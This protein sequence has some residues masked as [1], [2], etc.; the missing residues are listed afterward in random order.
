MMMKNKQD[1]KNF[2]WNIVGITFNSFNS[3]FFLIIVNRING[4]D[5]AGM[6]TYGF[7][8]ACLLWG[9]SMYYNR[10]YQVSNNE[11]KDNNFIK[12][13]IIFCI[14]MFL[15]SIVIAIVSTS[16]IQKILII[17][18]LCLFR[19]IEALADSFHGIIHKHNCLDY[20][21]KSLFFK[22]SIGIGVFLITDILTKNIILSIVSLVII[23]LLGTI[24]D[25]IKCKQFLTDKK[26]KLKE[27]FLIIFKQ[28]FP[29]FAFSFLSIFLL[30]CQK[31]IIGFTCKEEIQ[32]IFGIII[33]PA[34]IMSLCGQYLINPFL[35]SL[36]DKYKNDK[37]DE[38]K[39]IVLKLLLI[40][41]IGGILIA[42]IAYFVAIPIMNLLYGMILD[43]YKIMVS[44]IIA[45]ATF[46]SLTT[47]LSACL[48]IMKKNNSQLLI[49]VSVSL[50]SII[51]SYFFIDNMNITGAVISY[52]IMMLVHFVLYLV[53]YK[54]TL[55]KLELK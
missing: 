11:I 44:I 2:I 5:I 54:C 36:T 40:L 13:R 17:I 51:I 32:T 31:Y 39:N 50:F 14:I 38:F 53:Y 34:T 20:V 52:C 12:F 41:F 25:Y 7:A 23:N 43:S 46:Y 3:F 37:M 47:I 26:S 21:G 27:Q 19:N 24:V 28:A 9:I 22:A 8:I 16:N 1:R 29:I 42:I 49:Y 35:N 15:L 10:V 33:M 45:A 55:R 4:V 6:F 30:N 48:T 18:L